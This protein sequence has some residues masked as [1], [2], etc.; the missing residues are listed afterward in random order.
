MLLQVVLGALVV[1]VLAIGTEVRGFEAGK[2]WW[3]FKGYTNPWQAF[4]RRGSKVV[5]PM[6]YDF[7]TC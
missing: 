2:G 7:T 5:D 6:T 1:S 4:L 3:I